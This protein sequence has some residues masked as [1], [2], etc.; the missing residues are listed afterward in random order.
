MTWQISA[1]VPLWQPGPTLNDLLI[2][3]LEYLDELANTT[4]LADLAEA[5]ASEHEAILQANEDLRLANRAQLTAAVAALS[6]S[7]SSVCHP[8]VDRRV[9]A[10][11]TGEAEAGRI[12]HLIISVEERAPEPMPRL[13]ESAMYAPTLTQGP[14]PGDEEPGLSD[15]KI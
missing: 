7:V 1:N 2:H 12:R 3:G 15:V 5:P 4:R 8:D 9:L 13:D 14:A 10:V 6:I 11:L